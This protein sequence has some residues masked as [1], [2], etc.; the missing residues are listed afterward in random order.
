MR[1]A[2]ALLCAAAVVLQRGVEASVLASS[3]LETCLQGNADG[4]STVTLR[5]GMRGMQLTPA[6]ALPMQCDVVTL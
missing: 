3:S 6:A 1:H 5:H 2:A 4:S